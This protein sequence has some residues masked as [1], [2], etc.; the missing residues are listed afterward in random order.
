MMNDKFTFFSKVTLMDDRDNLVIIY[1]LVASPHTEITPM[2]EKYLMLVRKSPASVKS[3][4][5]NTGRI[6]A[7]KS[8]IAVKFV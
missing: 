7:S 8:R 1:K 3:E 5:L 6:T 2:I 4:K